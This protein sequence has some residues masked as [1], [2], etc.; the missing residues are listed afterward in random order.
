MTRRSPWLVVT[1]L[2]I[3]VRRAIVAGLLSLD[4]HSRSFVEFPSDSAPFAPGRTLAFPKAAGLLTLGAS[5]TPGVL[6]SVPG[7]N[8]DG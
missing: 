8:R 7:S 2:C 3:L 1:A 4:V 5:I 6:Y